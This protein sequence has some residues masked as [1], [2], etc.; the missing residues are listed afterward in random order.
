MR[1]RHLFGFTLKQSRQKNQFKAKKHTATLGQLA[2]KANELTR[3]NKENHGF[4]TNLA[5]SL[6]A[7]YVSHFKAA[8]CIRVVADVCDIYRR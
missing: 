4:K 1:R 7:G 6:R 2:A 5:N 8:F 3:H